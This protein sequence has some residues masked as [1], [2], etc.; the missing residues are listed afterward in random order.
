MQLVG[1]R[2]GLRMNQIQKWLLFEAKE[3]Q[4]LTHLKVNEDLS[5]IVLLILRVEFTTS[6]IT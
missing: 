4:D 5:I 2:T 6:H 1:I 3:D